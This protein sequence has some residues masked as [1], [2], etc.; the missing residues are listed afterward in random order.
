[1]KNLIIYLI[2]TIVL[3]SCSKVAQEQSKKETVVSPLVGKWQL[4]ETKISSGGPVSQW[5]IVT[6][7]FIRIF[8]A[9]NTYTT[10]EYSPCNTGSYTLD[11]NN[12][13]EFSN[14][15]NNATI[16]NK[17]KILSNTE[18]ELILNNV[19]CTEECQQKFKKIIVNN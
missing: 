10:T 17:Y 2:L 7:G 11:N 6:A 16:P 1:M 5:T 8:N 15:C 19:N 18:T 3:V 13:I 4:I 14:T 9:D 12:I